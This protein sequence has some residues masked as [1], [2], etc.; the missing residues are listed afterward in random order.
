M[1]LGS[2]SKGLELR[3]SLTRAPWN[4]PQS[5]RKRRFLGKLVVSNKKF[6]PV[7]SPAP[8]KKCIFTPSLLIYQTSLPHLTFPCDRLS[9]F[10]T[11]RRECLHLN[12]EY[13]HYLGT[14]I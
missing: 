13:L 12:T 5:M 11:L 2:N 8:P 4:I 6:E 14:G 9:F 7:T 10:N 1:A 3:G